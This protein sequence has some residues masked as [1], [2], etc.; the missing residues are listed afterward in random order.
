[1]PHQYIIFHSVSRKFDIVFKKNYVI[2]EHLPFTCFFQSIDQP[3]VIA[4]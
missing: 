3:L 1:M 2:T 4:H